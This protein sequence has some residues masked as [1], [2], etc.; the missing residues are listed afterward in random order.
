MNFFTSVAT[1]YSASYENFRKL[2]GAH[3]S[4][5]C[6]FGTPVIKRECFFWY[7]SGICREHCK[8]KTKIPKIQ[9]V[10]GR[11]FSIN[12]RRQKWNKL[13]K[14]RRESRETTKARFPAANLFENLNLIPKI[15][16]KDTML[17][18]YIPETPRRQGRGDATV[19][20][21]GPFRRR[22]PGGAKGDAEFSDLPQLPSPSASRGPSPTPRERERPSYNSYY[23]AWALRLRCQLEL[24]KIRAS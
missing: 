9:L 8:F 6:I 15:T 18:D 23:R 24:Q 5:G 17:N 22:T 1:H 11:C 14:S 12:L 4:H 20:G 16:D 21:R 2:V 3:S 19:A 10:P 13:P 7:P